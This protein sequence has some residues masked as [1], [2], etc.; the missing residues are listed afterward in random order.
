M[1]T[2]ATPRTESTQ[3]RGGYRYGNA[4]IRSLRCSAKIAAR[5]ASYAWDGP[6]V[7]RRYQGAG[8]GLGSGGKNQEPHKKPV[9]VKGG[10]RDNDKACAM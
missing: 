5:Y 7:V 9:K 4:S 1:R 6:D 2:R 8:H 10:R 3:F